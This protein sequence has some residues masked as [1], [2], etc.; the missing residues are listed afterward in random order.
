MKTLLLLA[1][2]AVGLLAQPAARPLIGLSVNGGEKARL[3]PGWP[4]LISVSIAPGDEPA[5]LALKEGSWLDAISVTVEAPDGSS[6]DLIRSTRMQPDA[7]DL[8]D[9]ETVTAEFMLSPDT[10][11]QLP[12]G[13]Y[14]VRAAFDPQGR[15]TEDAWPA[16]LDAVPASF[17]VNQ[18]PPEDEAAHQAARLLLFSHWSELQDDRPQ[19]LAYVD[20]LLNA[21][22]AHYTAKV[23]KAELLEAEG[24]FTEAL[25]LLDEVEVQLLADFP[26]AKH[27]PTL[28][29]RRQADLLDRILHTEGQGG[30]TESSTRK[31]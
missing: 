10:T 17:E 9:L 29:H 1:L 12:L 27:P 28:I 2:S 11:Q 20:E 16:R 25:Q 13:T 19:A 7:V 22:P 18:D 26:E 4:V 21:Q 8:R 23:R 15:Q 6:V 14:R 3:E 24:H 30:P 31:K 5:R